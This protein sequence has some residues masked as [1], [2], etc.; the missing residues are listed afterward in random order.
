MKKIQSKI[1]L[2]LILILTSASLYATA[3]GKEAAP[4]DS[5]DY[6]N[7]Y[8]IH[9]SLYELYKRSQVV[10]SKPE[11]MD[12]LDTMIVEAKKLGDKKGELVAAGAQLNS[13]IARK[14]QLDSIRKVAENVKVLSREYGFLQYYYFSS[15]A[16]VTTLIGRKKYIEAF[17][18][19]NE[20]HDM[21]VK[22]DY[23]YGL[24]YCTMS[25]GHLYFV[26]YNYTEAIK[27][28]YEAVEILE[29]RVT[30]QSPASV[31]SD[32]ADCCL[33]T[34]DYEQ[35]LTAVEK[36]LSSFYVS[37]SQRVHMLDERCSA[38]FWL[39]RYDEFRKAYAEC[40]AAIAK[41]GK[42]SRRTTEYSDILMK[43][44][45]GQYDEALAEL[46]DTH[47]DYARGHY[48]RLVAKQL[49][50]M[51]GDYKSAL[52][53]ADSI[54]VLLRSEYDLLIEND[55]ADMGARFDNEKLQLENARLEMEREK[56][57]YMYRRRNIAIALVSILA[58]LAVVGVFL[59]LLYKRNIRHVKAAGE[60]RY[61]F[62][63]N[64]S[65]EL[66]TPLSL[67]IGPLS[68]ILKKEEITNDDREKLVNILT[69]GERMKNL[70]NTVLTTSK[71]EAGATK[72]VRSHVNVNEWVR[73]CADSFKDEVSGYNS[74]I[75]LNIDESIGQINMDAQLCGIVFSNIMMN[76]IKHNEP[77]KPI[78]VSTKGLSDDGMVRISISDRGSGIGT[79]LEKLFEKYYT[80][81][82]ENAGF[83]IGLS[84]SKT[85]I[86]A[87][88][89][90]IGA[91]NNTD[92]KGA[93]FWFELPA[94]KFAFDHAAE[95][96]EGT[97]VESTLI[98]VKA[99]YDNIMGENVPTNRKSIELKNA[100]VMFVDDDPDLREYV[101]MELAE[102]CGEVF[103]AKHG[104]QALAML[105]DNGVDIVVS[106]VMMPFMDGLTLCRSIKS[107]DRLRHIP[108]ILLTARAD[109]N[110][111]REGFLASADCYMPK[112]FII[113]DLLD[114][115]AELLKG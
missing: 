3:P 115:M 90:K 91:Y 82:E 56:D 37:G 43:A 6:D 80:S 25:L 59:Y 106:D 78:T 67:I 87:H 109:D 69:Q 32:I 99:A 101:E 62:L 72:P 8:K 108:V 10:R 13:I 40:Q 89:G 9:N 38:L 71:I 17:D 45:N 60:E 16:V 1:I 46:K 52:N 102:S 35:V 47:G 54:E 68:R 66:R 94:T 74:D 2:T 26:S 111:I 93:T 27:N 95:P 23:P 84:Y 48:G 22:D 86:D 36:G 49:L 14:C 96:E 4:V 28:Y 39:G 50:K 105:E 31:Y 77:G 104:A 83:G 79:N 20:M 70:I 21:A 41:D 114:K 61:N 57:S 15:N 12:I 30:D 44:C 7:P 51:K 42:S 73:G 97:L 113:N 76:A 19:I 33:R 11:C 53:V 65:H 107:N 98:K 75:V 5:S 64:V 85:I 100:K 24:Y 34:R 81:T 63:V 103:V 92:G 112:P 18:R 88:R 58:I 110:S 29:T 55:L